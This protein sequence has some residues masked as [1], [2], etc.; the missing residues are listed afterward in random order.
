MRSVLTDEQNR[1]RWC[2]DSRMSLPSGDLFF[3][4]LVLPYE[5]IHILKEGQLDTLISA[6]AVFFDYNTIDYKWLTA[7]QKSLV[8][9]LEKRAITPKL[10]VLN[11][12]VHE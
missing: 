11:L 7:S 8:R 3:K 6:C 9:D 4:A 10:S 1:A 12:D 5:S 2:K